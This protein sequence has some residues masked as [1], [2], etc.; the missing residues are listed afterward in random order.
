[1]A[2]PKGNRFWEN[3][4]RH[5]LKKLFETPEILLEELNEYFQWCE[6]N[7]LIE[8]DWVGKDAKRVEKP[9]TRAFTWSGLEL[10]LGISSLRNYKDHENQPNYKDFQQVV[11]YAEKTIFTQKFEGAAAGMLNAN[12]IARDLGLVD[13]KQ[14]EIKGEQRLFNID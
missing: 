9:K 6:D 14:Q 2:A 7:P 8:I 3:R 12:I 10:Y 11:T 13:K 4:T 5:G 1:M